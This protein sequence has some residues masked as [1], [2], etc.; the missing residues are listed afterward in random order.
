MSLDV[1]E[2]KGDTECVG[3]V[4]E[5]VGAGGGHLFLGTLSPVSDTWGADV[6]PGTC[7]P[8][9]LSYPW[10]LHSIYHRAMGQQLE[11]THTLNFKIWLVSADWSN[12]S[13]SLISGAQRLHQRQKDL[14]GLEPSGTEM[15]VRGYSRPS[16][17]PT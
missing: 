13:A 1:P 17:S 2:V 4:A 9:P 12:V 8:S 11:N 14:F 5:P 3:E 6:S 7:G 15:W 16:L 10:H